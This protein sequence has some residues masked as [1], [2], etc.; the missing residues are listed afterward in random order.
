MARDLSNSEKLSAINWAA[1]KEG[2]S[3]GRF[4]GGLTAEKKEQIYLEYGQLLEKRQ[5][6]EAER[7][8]KAKDAKVLSKT[9]K[10]K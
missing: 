2:I 5:Q 3:Y 1:G 7:L 4:Q 9:R 6:E 8:Q 10:K